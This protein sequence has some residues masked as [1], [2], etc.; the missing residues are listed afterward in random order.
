MMKM[1]EYSSKEKLLQ[2]NLEKLERIQLNN[3]REIHNIK[4]QN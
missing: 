3:E 2:K 1:S 4:Q